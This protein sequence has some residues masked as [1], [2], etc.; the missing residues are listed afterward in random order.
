MTILFRTR[1][2]LTTFSKKHFKV[3]F[4]KIDPTSAKQHQIFFEV[5]QKK[6]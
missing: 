6:R 1:F 5:Y 4:F 3:K 2:S